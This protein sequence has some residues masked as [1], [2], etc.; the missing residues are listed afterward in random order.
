MYLIDEQ[1]FV[2]SN[3]TSPFQSPLCRGQAI[4]P[5]SPWRAICNQS[6]LN[7]HCWRSLCLYN[8]HSCSCN[9]VTNGCATWSPF[10][11]VCVVNP[12]ISSS[13]RRRSRVIIPRPTEVPQAAATAV[14]STI[15]RCSPNWWTII[16]GRAHSPNSTIHHY[17]SSML[18]LCVF[19][20]LPWAA[21]TTA[22]THFSVADFKCRCWAKARGRRVLVQRI[23]RVCLSLIASHSVAASHSS[24]VTHSSAAANLFSLSANDRS[25]LGLGVGGTEHI[26][27]LWL[28][29]FSQN[30]W[31]IIHA[32]WETNGILHSFYCFMT[33]MWKICYLFHGDNL[34]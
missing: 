13:P 7:K 14:A 27:V 31:C 4:T 30:M 9:K 1:F 16:I 21:T 12:P 10:A 15:H 25:R 28:E 29:K 23:G 32:E 17:W 19:S 5:I 3:V 8:R 26:G 34:Q 11:C 33:W 18:F 2:R 6:R 22:T 20:M 24:L